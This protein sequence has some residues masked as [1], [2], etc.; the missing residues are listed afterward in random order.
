MRLPIELSLSVV[1]EALFEDGGDEVVHGRIIV[2][3]H[4]GFVPGRNRFRG[5]SETST[6][7]VVPC[8][9]S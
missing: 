6:D 7:F 2:G 8:G 1:A 3:Q 4:Q 5:L 9:F